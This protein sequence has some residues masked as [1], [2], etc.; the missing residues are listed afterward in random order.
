LYSCKYVISLIKWRS[1]GHV[2]FIAEIGS[3][4]STV[5]RK[6]EEKIQLGRHRLR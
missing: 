3:V 1:I 4:L 2:S 6:P 5:V